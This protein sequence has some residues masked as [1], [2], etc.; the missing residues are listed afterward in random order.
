MIKK[1]KGI[2][3]D[4]LSDIRLSEQFPYISELFYDEL[5]SWLYLIIEY[6]YLNSPLR[7]MPILFEQD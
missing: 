6:L 1:K 2:D 4:S 7:V 5:A 3:I